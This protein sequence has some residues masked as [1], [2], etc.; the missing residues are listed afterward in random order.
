MRL[1]HIVEGQSAGDSLRVDA[2]RS[3][4]D[5]SDVAV[6]EAGRT[7]IV[8]DH[9]RIPAVANGARVTRLRPVL[10]TR[11]HRYV[12]DTLAKR[13]GGAWD[14]ANLPQPGLRLG[15]RW[16]GGWCRA[17]ERKRAGPNHRK[18]GQIASHK[19]DISRRG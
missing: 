12:R 17:A 11:Q 4:G 15:E 9:G 2:E 5:D 13:I 14:A 19:C 10:E 7:A 16:L 1:E 3:R 8:I 6:S 18:Q